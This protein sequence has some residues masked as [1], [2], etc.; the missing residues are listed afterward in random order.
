[1]SWVPRAAKEERKKKWMKQFKNWSGW[2]FFF[3]FWLMF[4]FGADFP[5]CIRSSLLSGGGG[6]LWPPSSLS[7]SLW[8]LCWFLTCGLS[9]GLP[10]LFLLGGWGWLVNWSAIMPLFFISVSLPTSQPTW[11]AESDRREGAT[12]GHW[13]LTGLILKRSDLGKPFIPGVLPLF[14]VFLGITFGVCG[15]CFGHP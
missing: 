13:K 12:G 10:Q 14:K 8:L 4:Y 1:M 9:L 15:A 2:V 11:A 6:L 5:V 7:S 3:F